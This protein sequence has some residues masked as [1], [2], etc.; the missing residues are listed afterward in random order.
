MKQAPYFLLITAF[1]VMSGFFILSA[2]PAHGQTSPLPTLL[3][4]CFPELPPSDPN[5]CGVPAFFQLLNNV[6]N[7]LF[8]I[9]MPI[10]GIL[11]MYGGV[12]I[13]T[14]AGNVSR[15]AQG[16]SVITT[17]VVGIVIALCSWLIIYSVYNLLGVSN[18]FRGP[19]GL[20]TQGSN[21]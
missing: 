6:M 21:P 16:K 8:I 7:W 3:P 17:A 12:L 2:A 10:A 19:V 14:A 1:V 15:I 4:R 18:T 13:M 5:A 11:I 20:P 9:V